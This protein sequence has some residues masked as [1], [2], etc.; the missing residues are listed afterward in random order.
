MQ[1]P[2][3]REEMEFV[4]WEDGRS[5]GL[6]RKNHLCTRCFTYVVE[7]FAEDEMVGL[8]TGYFKGKDTDE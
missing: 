1:C 3:C 7:L 5:K 2:T 6:R 8:I 4:T